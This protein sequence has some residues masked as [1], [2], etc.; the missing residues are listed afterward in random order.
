MAKGTDDAV[1]I[2]A[3]AV[4]RTPIAKRGVAAAVAAGDAAPIQIATATG[5]AAMAD[6]A[7][8]APTRTA[9]S[10]GAE[11]EPAVPAV[12]IATATV[13]VARTAVAATL[14]VSVERSEDDKYRQVEEEA[15]QKEEVAR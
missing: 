7:L 2:V 13:A 14:A 4:A 15:Q 3:R 5:D 6:A 11:T 10:V 9:V 12:P 8:A 1:T